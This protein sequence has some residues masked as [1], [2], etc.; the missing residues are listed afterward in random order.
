LQFRRVHLGPQQAAVGAGKKVCS[1]D[2]DVAATAEQA[3]F[4]WLKILHTAAGNPI[5]VL[6]LHDSL[7]LALWAGVLHNFVVNN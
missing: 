2:G 3:Q 6:A 4:L 1:F 5:E 7:A